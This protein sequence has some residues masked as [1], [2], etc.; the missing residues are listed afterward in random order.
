MFQ[1]SATNLKTWNEYT[2]SKFLDRLREIGNIYMYQD[3]IYNI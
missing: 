2:E 3:K 1:G